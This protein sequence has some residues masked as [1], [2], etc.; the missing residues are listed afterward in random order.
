MP[1]SRYSETLESVLPNLIVRPD[2]SSVHNLRRRA[3]LVLA[4]SR[5][6]YRSDL[7]FYGGVVIITADRYPFA[8][9]R[10][11]GLVHVHSAKNSGS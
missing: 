6:N 11:E 3:C 10:R 9:L 2:G 1:A 4:V 5:L 7:S 8:N